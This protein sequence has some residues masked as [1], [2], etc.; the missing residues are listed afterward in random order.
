MREAVDNPDA[1]VVAAPVHGVD[2]AIIAALSVAGPTFRMRH[3][4]VESA[5][6]AVKRA[7]EV[8]ADLVSGR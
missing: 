3:E 1:T 6:L 7:A 2:G 5:G 4:N 8:L